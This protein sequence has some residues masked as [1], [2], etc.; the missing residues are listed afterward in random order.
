LVRPTAPASVPTVP[1]STP[2][3]ATPRPVTTTTAPAGPGQLQLYVKPWA[4]VSVDGDDKGATPLKPIEL[5]AGTHQVVLK[6]PSYEPLSRQVTI[7]PGSTTR[8]EINLP[9]E[10]QRLP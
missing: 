8:L 3:P 9:V 5:G 6:H 2:L 1:P 4:Q 7:Q 10:G